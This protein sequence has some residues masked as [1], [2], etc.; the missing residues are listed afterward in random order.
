MVSVLFIWKEV[1]IGSCL[2]I[3]FEW[4]VLLIYTF[5]VVRVLRAGVWPDLSSAM[6]TM[7]SVG[8]S[9]PSDCPLVNQV[10][11]LE[12]LINDAL[13]TNAAPMQVNA[14]IDSLNQIQPQLA[15]NNTWT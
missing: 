15:A 13:N 5:S 11:R 2:E 10:R 14:V 8:C 12:R 1:L 4:T 7:P 9:I 6:V 3:A